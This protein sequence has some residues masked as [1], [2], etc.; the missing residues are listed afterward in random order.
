MMESVLLMLMLVAM[1]ALLIFL[2]RLAKSNN[3]IGR[4]IKGFWNFSLTIWSFI[5]F[6][7]WLAKFMIAD[8]AEEQAAKEN[9][10]KI[11]E[12]ADDIARGQMMQSAARTRAELQAIEEKADLE[13]RI[14]SELGRTDARIVGNNKVEIGGKP[15]D[16]DKLLNDLH[17][18]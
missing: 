3:P 16:L 7:G 4:L 5:P 1:V 13:R 11:G 18:H 17:I 14:N 12:S 15:V 8:T 9:Q 6:C 2:R 10:I